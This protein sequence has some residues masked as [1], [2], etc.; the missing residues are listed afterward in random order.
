MR[1]NL[2]GLLRDG[3]LLVNVDIISGLLALLDTLREI[4]GSIEQ[5]PGGQ[6]R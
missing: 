5:G 3:K 4:L 1:E 6:W 2:L